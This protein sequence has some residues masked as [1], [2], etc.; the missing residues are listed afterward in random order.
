MINDG[1]VF[2]TIHGEYI[3]SI[4]VTKFDDNKCYGENLGVKYSSKLSR[5]IFNYF[6]EREGNFNNK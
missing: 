5:L 4:F 6:M 2:S 1:G 3:I